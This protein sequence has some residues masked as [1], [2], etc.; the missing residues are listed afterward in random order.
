MF[1]GIIQTLGHVEQWLPRGDDVRLCIHAADL[2]LSTAH[3]GDSIAVSG[4]CLTAVKIV[5]NDFW[6]DVS[7]E[8]LSRTNINHLRP[9]SKVNLE[10]ALTLST[11]LGGHLVSGH[12]DGIGIVNKRWDD[13]RSVRFEIQAPA[14]LAKYIAQKGSICIDGISLTV[15]EIMGTVFGINIVPHTLH[16]TTMHEFQVGREVNL[17]VDLVARYLERLI[18]GD[19]GAEVSTAKLDKAFLSKHGFIEQNKR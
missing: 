7:A 15:N 16:A 8:T 5:E 18:L 10:K 1:T 2:D 12:I 9:G 4:V 14:E 3:L 19:A 6:A 17:E 13:G 11:P